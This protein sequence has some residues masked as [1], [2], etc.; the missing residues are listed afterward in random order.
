[1]TAYDHL[2]KEDAVVLLIDHQ[3]GLLSL[4]QDFSPEEFR[5]NVMALADLAVFFKLPTILND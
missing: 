3:A 1:M 2:S 4:V 5:N